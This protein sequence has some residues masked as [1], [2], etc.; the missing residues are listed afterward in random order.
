MK[1]YSRN[2]RAYSKVYSEKWIQNVIRQNKGKFGLS[3]LSSVFRSLVLLLPTLIVKEI[4]NRAIPQENIVMLI[5]LSSLNVSIYV[6]TTTLIILDLRLEKY[7]LDAFGTLRRDMYRFFLEKPL[8]E[9]AA[10]RSG[11]A[12]SKIVDETEGLANFFYFGFGSLVWIN[13]TVFAGMVIMAAQNPLLAALTISLM[14]LRIVLIRKINQKQEKIGQKINETSSRV[15]QT[16]KEQMSNILFIKATASEEKEL[17]RVQEALAEKYQIQRSAFRGKILNKAVF[18][19]FELLINLLFY[20]YGGLLIANGKMLPGT[21]VALVAAY[22]WIVPALNGYIDLHIDFRQKKSSIVRVFGVFADDAGGVSNPGADG[23]GSVDGA[24]NAQGRAAEMK[25]PAD[26]G[27]TDSTRAEAGAATA[28]DSVADVPGGAESATQPE[29][30]AY[31]AQDMFPTDVGII[32]E[33]LSYRYGEKL[34]LSDVSFQ[35]KSGEFLGICGKSG[36]GKSTLANLMAGLLDGYDGNIFI[37]GKNINWI[38]HE[39]M[40]ENLIYL[41][42]DGYLMNR[43]IRDNILFYS[44]NHTEEE[45]EKVLRLVKL[46]DWIKKLP[47][48]LDTIVGERANAISGGERQRILLARALLRNPKIFIFDES[49]SAL[50]VNTEKEILEN[51]RQSYPDATRIFITHREN[52]LE[53][54]DRVLLIEEGRL[55]DK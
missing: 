36:S 14:I 26:T 12:I 5:L 39:W 24:K 40:T 43:S 27:S 13:T 49:I 22:D 29:Y 4:I 32:V 53:L 38:P 33:H 25:N 44:Q 16:V 46:E 6:V 31:K 21:L 19:I 1:D 9:F 3:L 47:D 23:A 10:I 8:Q 2:D 55:F 52:C 42:Q 20:L 7:I 41:G 50:D 17:N 37:G 51:I 45:L 15:N 54:F 11:D 34:V 18:G 28:G 35:I 48:G 30:V